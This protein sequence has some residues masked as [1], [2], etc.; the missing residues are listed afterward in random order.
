[1]VEPYIV[2]PQFD[3]VQLVNIPTISRTG[4][5]IELVNEGYKLT[6]TSLGGTTLYKKWDVYHLSTGDSDFAGPSTVSLI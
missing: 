6:F 5:Y 4:R 3:S 1:M 2:V